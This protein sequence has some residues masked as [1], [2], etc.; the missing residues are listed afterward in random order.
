MVGMN[1]SA[2]Y[3]GIDP[4]LAVAVMRNRVSPPDLTAAVE[5]DRIVIEA[6]PTER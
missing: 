5:V 2:A 3:A 1:G 4:G 6:F